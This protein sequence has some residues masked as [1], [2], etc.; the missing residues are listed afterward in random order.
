MET[1]GVE[2]KNAS[3]RC[4]WRVEA[5]LLE[6]FVDLP[7]VNP[8]HVPFYRLRIE[9]LRQECEFSSTAPI[10]LPVDLAQLVQPYI[11]CIQHHQSD[12]KS[13]RQKHGFP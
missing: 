10:P 7:D 1:E 6:I 11:R 9:E 12:L 4:S 8:I 5:R 3:R 13:L 2:E